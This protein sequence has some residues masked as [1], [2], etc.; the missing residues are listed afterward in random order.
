MLILKDAFSLE[1]L[2]PQTMNEL[3]EKMTNDPFGDD[4]NKLFK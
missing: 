1:N 3:V 2:F 4:A